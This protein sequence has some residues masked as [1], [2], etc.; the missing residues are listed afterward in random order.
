MKMNRQS[1][2]RYLLFSVAVALALASGVPAAD[3]PVKDGQKIA[4]LG[5]SITQQ[6]AGSGG[7]LR[8][9]ISGLEANGS[10]RRPFLPASAATNRIRCWMRSSRRAEQEA[11]LDDPELRR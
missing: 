7:Y 9:V 11:G 5:D 8:L 4:F 6:G 2:K 3:L 10:R 1:E